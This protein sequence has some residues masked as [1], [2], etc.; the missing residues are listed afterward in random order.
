M[1]GAELLVED[2]KAFLCYI[3]YM[4]L[5]RLDINGFKSFGERIS[6]EFVPGVTCIVGP[7][8]SGKSN[9]VDAIRWALGEQGYKGIRLEKSDDVI[10]LGS[11]GKGKM[12]RASVEMV[13]TDIPEEKSLGYEE[14]T[15]SRHVYRDGEG[16][17][18]M[19]RAQVRLK[20]TL[21]ILAQLHIST[22]NYSIVTQG[23]SDQLLR[24][25]PQELRATLEDASGVKDWQLKKRDS[26]RKLARSGE[27]AGQVQAL[28]AELK[29]YLA[30]LRG[31]MRRWEKREEYEKKI[32]ELKEIKVYA[33]LRDLVGRKKMMNDQR[34]RLR[35]LIDRLEEQKR[36]LS[37]DI[38]ETEKRILAYGTVTPNAPQG[39]TALEKLYERR[40]QLE[41]ELIRVESQLASFASARA[42]HAPDMGHIRVGVSRI[43]ILLEAL[44]HESSPDALKKGIRQ[45][46]EA[47]ESV[48]KSF[49]APEN[50]VPKEISDAQQK[51]KNT[52]G[53][54]ERE[55]DESKRQNR[56][57]RTQEQQAKEELFQK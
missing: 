33:V 16:E 48:E 22:K 40:M 13:L 49:D 50:S 45:A 18:F 9:V 51:L 11:R 26:E 31:Q 1:I 15:V 54:L 14:L 12:S 37:A 52:I 7:N 10:F 56:Q 44:E 42:Q 30:N 24:F 8:G 20:D 3:F 32:Q 27:H 34:A 28:L 41:R 17:Y 57:A 29:P 43:R 46:L 2:L 53:E 38:G 4:H 5:R 25:T 55:M 36:A 23:M 47:A 21:E 19:N 39:D 35:A 6:L